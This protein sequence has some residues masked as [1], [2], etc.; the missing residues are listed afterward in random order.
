MANQGDSHR[1]H[2]P[3]PGNMAALSR[4]CWRALL[5]AEDVLMAAD[6]PE[7]K[8]RACNTIGQMSGYYTRICETLDLV[9]RVE[10]LEQALK[11]RGRP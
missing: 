10:A 8:L 11:H 5:T 4:I 9:A 7:L 1:K 3:Q 6:T 2:R